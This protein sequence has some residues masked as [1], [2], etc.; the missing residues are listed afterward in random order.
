MGCGGG[1]IGGPTSSGSVF[2]KV[3]AGALCVPGDCRRETTASV[4]CFH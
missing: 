2:P 3:G 4:P 1:V